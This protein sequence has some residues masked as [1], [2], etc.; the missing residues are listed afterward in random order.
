MGIVPAGKPPETRAM[1]PA[2][3]SPSPPPPRIDLQKKLQQASWRRRRS[4]I[5]PT[6]NDQQRAHHN[7]RRRRHRHTRRRRR[8]RHAPQ[9]LKKTWRRR[10]SHFHWETPTQSPTAIQSDVAVQRRYDVAVR[11]RYDENNKNRVADDLINKEN[12]VADNRRRRRRRQ[13]PQ[14]D[15]D[16]CGTASSMMKEL[17]FLEKKC[18]EA[19]ESSSDQLAQERLQALRERNQQLQHELLSLLS[20]S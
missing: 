6:H 12:K 14:C 18:H 2:V 10:R 17:A 16:K 7:G 19:P 1:T 20:E 3:N 8:R 4:D 15:A 5:R 11:R 13:L 9:P